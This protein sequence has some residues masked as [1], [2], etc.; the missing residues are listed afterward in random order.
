MHRLDSIPR[1]SL[2]RAFSAFTL[3]AFNR[4]PYASSSATLASSS[5]TQPTAVLL[6]ASS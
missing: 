2:R 4:W 5:A 3:S 6:S 1:F